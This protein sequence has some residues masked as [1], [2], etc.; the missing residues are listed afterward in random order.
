MSSAKDSAKDETA[1][2]RRYREIQ[3]QKEFDSIIREILRE[4]P[5]LCVDDICFAVPVYYPIALIELKIE[6]KLFEEFDGVE[7]ELLQFIN[8]IGPD[9]ETLSETMG[10]DVSFV[11]KMMTVMAGTGLITDNGLSESGKESLSAGTKIS[12]EVI[13]Q[14]FQMDAVNLNLL[15]LEELVNEGEL[16][17]RQDTN[18]NYNLLN[19]WH[20]VSI[21]KLDSQLKSLDPKEF[22]VSEKE[23]LPPNIHGIQSKRCKGL[24]YT[25]SCLLGINYK[26]GNTKKER[27]IIFGKRKL[28]SQVDGNEG[29]RFSR[30]IP[31][32][33]PDEILKEKY[34]FP[35]SIR[36]SHSL[37]INNLYNDV[38]HKN[39][40]EMCSVW[41][42]KNEERINV[43]GF[44]NTLSLYKQHLKYNQIDP[45][46]HID[47][48]TLENRNVYQAIY[49]KIYMD[50]RIRR[51]SMLL[52]WLQNLS[53]QK[54]IVCAQLGWK[55]G[56]MVITTEDDDLL[57]LCN[58]VKDYVE[59]RSFETVKSYLEERMPYKSNN[60]IDNND[61]QYTYTFADISKVFEN[62]PIEDY[63]EDK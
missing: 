43:D 55:G 14:T 7:Y 26:I 28:I 27:P 25:K 31:F 51:P 53:K 3:K 49:I 6:E 5:S 21:E 45:D 11:K 12:T 15:R 50:T 2:D 34:G 8:D 54:A 52:N 9:V 30:W 40:H 33:V 4:Y 19:C 59:Q 22:I 46:S 44:E 48:K 29:K 35:A 16:T 36:I 47:Y 63:K 32:S 60:D 1:K 39:N 58:E 42:S 18:N 23:L 41:D 20:S 10:L 13:G 62:N 57:K 61:L 37:M 17:K 56:I 24:R 38:R